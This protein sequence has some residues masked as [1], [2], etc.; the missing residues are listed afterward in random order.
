VHRA[1]RSLLLC[2]V[3]HHDR[4][5]AWAERRKIETHPT[6]GAAQLVEIRERVQEVIVPTFVSQPTAPVPRKPLFADLTDA[7]L[8]DY[9]VPVEWMADVR[10]ATED[11]VLGL[12]DH[13]PA[14]AGLGVP[15]RPHR[16]GGEADMRAT[17]V[18]ST[19]AVVAAA[20]RRL[21][22]AYSSTH[23]GPDHDP[24]A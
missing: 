3:D 11:T 20:E 17:R 22:A 23:G 4:A 9:G 24:P 8:L 10:Q 19:E 2:Y 6:T 18:V 1:D 15:G 7:D 21:W 16:T 13:L 5:Y 14:E 12:A